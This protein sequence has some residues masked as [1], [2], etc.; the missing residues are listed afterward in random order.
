[1]AKR[2]DKTAEVICPSCGAKLV[3]DAFLGKVISHE[4]PPR[5]NKSPDFDRVGELLE[6]EK[7]RREQIFKQSAA[8]EK[9]KSQVLERRFEE[10]LK[11]SK[12][13][14]I[15]RPTRDIDLD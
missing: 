14:P 7:E 11:K 9:V 6:K 2:K 5:V 4:P 3:V 15:I 8:D 13:E 1:M 10:A 12:D